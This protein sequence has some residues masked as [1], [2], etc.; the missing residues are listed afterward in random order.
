MKNDDIENPLIYSRYDLV[1]YWGT[2]IGCFF[3]WTLFCV[4]FGWF[5]GAR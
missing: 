4:L 3:G 1:K 5:I 2:I